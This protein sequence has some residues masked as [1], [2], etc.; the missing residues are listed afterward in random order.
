MKTEMRKEFPLAN[1]LQLLKLSEELKKPMF[2]QTLLELTWFNYKLI[3]ELTFLPL[4]IMWV[5][6]FW[7]VTAKE[8]ILI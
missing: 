7:S 6:H 2:K 3:K 8:K 5:S 1:T 4:F